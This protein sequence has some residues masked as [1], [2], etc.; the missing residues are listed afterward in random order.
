MVTG[1]CEFN[2]QCDNNKSIQMFLR[3]YHNQS[4]AVL[5]NCSCD[6]NNSKSHALEVVSLQNSSEA[7]GVF[8]DL[9]NAT[10]AENSPNHSDQLSVP[11]LVE[12]AVVGLVILTIHS[13]NFTVYLVSKLTRRK[14]KWRNSATAWTYCRAE[15]A[16]DSQ[17]WSRKNERSER[18]KFGGA[19]GFTTLR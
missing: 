18:G 12:A 17:H 3:P 16:R 2:S 4:E 14:R 1:N 15:S 11:S 8:T 6:L 5:I 19:V 13:L 9:Q 7:P 10:I